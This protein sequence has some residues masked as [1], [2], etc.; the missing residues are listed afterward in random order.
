MSFPEL[1]KVILS[2]ADIVV[3]GDSLNDALYLLTGAKDSIPAV[4]VD[5]R[6]KDLSSP[7]MGETGEDDKLNQIKDSIKNLKAEL[8]TIESLFQ[9][10]EEVIKG[11]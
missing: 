6:E 7:A 1:K 8:D 9:N 10:L 3:M 5:E 4:S 2:T 11:E